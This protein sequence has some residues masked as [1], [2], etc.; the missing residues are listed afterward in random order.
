VV[1]AGGS[2]GARAPSA[3]PPFSARILSTA[4]RQYRR[5]PNS[6]AI[7]P[8]FEDRTQPGPQGDLEDATSRQQYL[9][10]AREY[11]DIAAT[12]NGANQKKLLEEA[13]A[14]KMT[15][16]RSTRGPSPQLTDASCLNC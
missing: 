4:L 1:L 16:T 2:L 7:S 6:W 9:E 14:A 12:M 3:P 15:R 11:I 13:E 5:C 8:I 10:R